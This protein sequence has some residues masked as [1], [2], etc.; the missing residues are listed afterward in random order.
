MVI[1]ISK[2]EELPHPG[3]WDHDFENTMV[4][5]EIVIAYWSCTLKSTERNYSP[6]D[7]EVLALHDG[8]IKFQ[9]YIEGEK[10][11]AIT[12]HAALIWSRTFQ[13]VNWH[14]LTWGTVFAAYPDLKIVHRAGRVHSNVDPI[15][16]L[17]R[18]IPYQDGPSANNSVATVLDSEMD[19]LEDLYAEIS[20]Q[21][22]ACT[23]QLMADYEEENLKATM[24]IHSTSV[25]IPD[26]L[27]ERITIPYVTAKTFNLVS[28]LSK[29]EIQIFVDAYAKDPYF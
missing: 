22:E 26:K 19:P 28:S 25:N 27:Q 15:S 7:R 12:D 24:K 18:N 2:E 20:P 3:T 1:P 11:E 9:P 23:L 10:I 8:L 6:T 29:E 14:L 16:R 5:V 4:H 17:R 21:F 13:N